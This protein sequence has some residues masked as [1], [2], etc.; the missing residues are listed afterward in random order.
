[1]ES[2]LWIKIGMM[3]VGTAVGALALRRA[4]PVQPLSGPEQEEPARRS[5]DPESER[6][7]KKDKR[8]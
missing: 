3:L 4:F 6:S 2:D 5:P 1:V 7:K 8:R